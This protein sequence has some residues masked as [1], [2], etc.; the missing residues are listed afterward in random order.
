MARPRIYVSRRI[1]EAVCKR[2]GDDFEVSYHDSEAPP[3]RDVLLTSVAGVDG[4]IVTLSDTVDDEFFDAAGT[5]LQVVANYAVGYDNID[6]VAATRR[7]VVATNTPDVLT[8]ATAEF[9]I[10]LMLSL[11]RR[12]RE[13]DRLLRRRE[14]W[15][16]A[17]TMMLGTPHDRL[18]GI[19]GFGRIGQEV[20]RLAS[21]LG[22]RVI[23]SDAID[24]PAARFEQ[25][26]FTELLARSDIV[27]LHCPLV[28]E[29]YH[30]LGREEFA[31]MNDH[32]YLVN[33]A[34]GP[35]VDEVALYRAL[36]DG[37]IAGA[38]LDVFEQEPKVTEGLLELENVVLTPHL[39]S[40]TQEAREAMGLLCVSALRAVLL[41]QRH[42]AN[43]LHGLGPAS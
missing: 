1:P 26:E 17:P 2:L 12:V 21:G 30:L 16:W 38:A 34:R 13:G 5:Q 8:R 3:A 36:V 10:A 41:E 37:A 20:A 4:C 19:V 42:P 40:A 7:G 9:A 35:I 14:E 11:L 25:A 18:L 43:A 6:V 24:R 32:A 23:F 28:V 15:T 31:T 33:T 39:A 22:M 29:T 27:S